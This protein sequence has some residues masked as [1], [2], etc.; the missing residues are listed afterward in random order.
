MS[1]ISWAGATHHRLH[2]TQALHLRVELDL[3]FRPPFAPNCL[4]RAP[5]WVG[6]EA[7][8]QLQNR[9]KAWG[10]PSSVAWEPPAGMFFASFCII[11]WS[12]IP[13]GSC[14]RIRWKGE[15]CWKSEPWQSKKDRRRS[16]TFKNLH[17]GEPIIRLN[18]RKKNNQFP[19]LL[20]N[21]Q[22]FF[23][24]ILHPVADVFPQF[25]WEQ[26]PS[27]RRFQARQARGCDAGTVRLDQQAAFHRF[28]VRAKGLN[29]MGL[30]AQL[31]GVLGWWR[32]AKIGHDD[33]T[34]RDGHEVAHTNE[35]YGHES[36]RQ[37]QNTYPSLAGCSWLVGFQQRFNSITISNP[38]RTGRIQR[39][40]AT[41][42]AW[43]ECKPTTWVRWHNQH[44]CWYPEATNIG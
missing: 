39:G 38:T 40:T 9:Q 32:L 6:Y 34:E 26:C 15:I 24:P 4:V 12:Q 17:A 7:R 10:S 13:L 23:N 41:A 16:Q 8:C 25:R 3:L 14:W 5:G 35:I 22:H 19:W 36:G 33:K 2:Q 44:Q 28:D 30:A 29:I 18:F 43:A 1:W 21:S 42:R 11:F 37:C 27:P 31:D 20:W